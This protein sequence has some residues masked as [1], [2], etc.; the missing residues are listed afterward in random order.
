MEIA[1]VRPR[2][3]GGAPTEL[4][5]DTADHLAGPPVPAE[6]VEL[7]HHAIEREF[8]A[9]DGVVG[10]TVALALQAMVAAL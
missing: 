10:I 1:V 4:V 8:D 5:E 6:D 2:L 9:D 7:R 3:L